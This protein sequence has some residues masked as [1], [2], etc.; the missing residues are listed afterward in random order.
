MTFFWYM[1]QA[2]SAY[3]LQVMILG[4][5]ALITASSMIPAC[6]HQEKQRRSQHAQLLP[7]LPHNTLPV[8]CCQLLAGT[9]PLHA[10]PASSPQHCSMPRSLCSLRAA[11]AGSVP[12]PQYGILLTA[13]QS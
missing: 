12:G 9:S 1:N 6:G 2:A 7:V 11:H 8:R 13:L 10:G 5:M 3:W 4:V